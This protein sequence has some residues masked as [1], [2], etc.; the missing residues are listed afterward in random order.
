MQCFA[1]YEWASQR[2][3]SGVRAEHRVCL[4]AGGLKRK[5]VVMADYVGEADELGNLGFKKR[6]SL[7]GQRPPGYG[8][9]MYS[10]YGRVSSSGQTGRAGRGACLSSLLVLV[11]CSGQMHLGCS[12]SLLA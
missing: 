5:R 7:P 2:Q 10:G 12:K 3:L 9:A 8:G 1:V 11:P 6:K 4:P